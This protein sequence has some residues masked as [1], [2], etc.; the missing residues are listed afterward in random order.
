ME[1][2]PDEKKR[3]E[4][5]SLIPAA[6]VVYIFIG[7]FVYLNRNNQ[8]IPLYFCLIYT[9]AVFLF[10]MP[11]AMFLTEIILTSRKTKKPLKAYTKT[12]FGRM[13]LFTFAA[14]LCGSILSIAY[15]ALSSLFSENLVVILGAAIFFI[16]LGII[17]FH[18][19]EKIN[20]ISNGEW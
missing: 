18:Y 5:L 11:G 16:I 6:I 10:A 9:G 4:K 14:I 19:K 8:N 2:S 3:I 15:L 13:L 17:V 7:L 1:L 12:F 20:K